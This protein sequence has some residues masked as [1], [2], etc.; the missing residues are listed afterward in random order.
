MNQ[1]TLYIVI[2]VLALAVIVLGIGWYNAAQQPSGIDI[3]LGNGGVS[4]KTN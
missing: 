4:I 2:G 3:N 1:R